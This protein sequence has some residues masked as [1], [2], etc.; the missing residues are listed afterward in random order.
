MLDNPIVAWS[1]F[2]S[3]VIYVMALIC[4]YVVFPCPEDIPERT[5][6]YLTGSLF[7][8]I[9]VSLLPIFSVVMYRIL[10][11]IWSQMTFPICVPMS[12]FMLF[13]GV[14]GLFVAGFILTMFAAF[15]MDL[16]VGD[17]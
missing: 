16:L 12:L 2:A 1:L 9:V 3:V 13:G 4:R 17:D 5:L 8:F 14:C 7:G 6:N 10:V 11:S 15:L